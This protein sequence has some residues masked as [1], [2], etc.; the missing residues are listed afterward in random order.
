M[1]KVTVIDK[2]EKA[3]SRNNKNWMDLLRIA[4]NSSPKKISKILAKI[5]KEDKNISGFAKKLIKQNKK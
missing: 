5:Y 2:I 4:H 1:K 3:R